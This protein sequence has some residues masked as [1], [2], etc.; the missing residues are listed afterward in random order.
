MALTGFYPV[1]NVG[2]DGFE[3]PL[4][5]EARLVMEVSAE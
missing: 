4:F 1:V 3:A 2:C 5:C